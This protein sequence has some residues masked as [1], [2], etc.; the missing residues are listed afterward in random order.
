MQ[1]KLILIRHAKSSWGNPLQPDFERELNERGKHDA[2]HMGKKLKE[3][4]LSPDLIIAS[5]AKRTVQTARKIASAVGYET[6]NIKCEEK[7]YH[8]TPSVFEDMICGLDNKITTV[9]IVAHNPGI[10]EFVNG[11]SHDFKIDNMPTCGVVGATMD[12]H[13]WS[14]FS[15]AKRNVFLYEYPGKDDK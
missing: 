5:S 3:L 6:D 13:E 7:L 9:F 15:I 14:D 10:T 11:L 1:R 12:A 2:P 4:K 8:C